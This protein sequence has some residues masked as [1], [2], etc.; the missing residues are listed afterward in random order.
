MTVPQQCRL[1]E[2]AICSSLS[3]RFPRRVRG[4]PDPLEVVALVEDRAKVEIEA[5]AVIP[6]NTTLSDS[7]RRIPLK[8]DGEL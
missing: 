8:T 2:I 1:N 5:T 4:R 3:R 7:Q 6:I